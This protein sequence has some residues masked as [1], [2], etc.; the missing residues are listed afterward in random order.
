MTAI[1]PNPQRPESTGRFLGN[2]RTCDEPVH[3]DCERIETIVFER[4]ADVSTA[5]AREIAG[6]IRARHA[7]GR[8]CVLGLATGSTPTQVYGELVRM[9][10]EEGLS[11]ANV[12]TFNLDEYWPMP[13]EALQ[14]YRR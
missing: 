8:S 12:V 4:A 11:F 7:E 9:H 1:S 3:F 14:S 6:L 13:P 2:G 10:R 5:I